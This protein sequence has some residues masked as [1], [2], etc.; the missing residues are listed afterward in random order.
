MYRF[1]GR[2]WRLIVGLPLSDGT[3]KDRTVS[4]DEEP[5][6]EQ[7]RCLHKCIAKVN[8]SISNHNLEVSI[9]WI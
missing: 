6:I 4:V 8:I 3:F 9:L 2:T 7:L 1:L 5:T